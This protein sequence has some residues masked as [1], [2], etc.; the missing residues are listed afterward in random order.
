MKF[1][2]VDGES[3]KD[4]SSRTNSLEAI[5]IAK[6]LQLNSNRIVNNHQ[7]RENAEAL[8]ENR[9]PKIV[10]LSEIVGIITPFKGQKLMIKS[11]LKKN[12][13]DTSGLTIGTVHAL[14]GAERPIILFS[15]VY[16]K[17]NMGGGYFFDK[18]VNMLNVA[19]SRAKEN[20][21]VFGCPEVFQGSN[22]TPSSLLYKHI[23]RVENILV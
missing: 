20:F 11:A 1:I 4:G 21:I 23:E 17:N 6:W 8:R 10:T 3:F 9:K 12:S 19:V 18:G 16:G 2:P 13:I 22:G 15:S 7:D 14:Q 5:E